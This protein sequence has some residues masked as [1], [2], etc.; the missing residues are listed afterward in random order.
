M[1][2]KNEIESRPKKTPLAIAKRQWS[3]EQTLANLSIEGM[4][5]SANADEARRAYIAGEITTEERVAIL[6]A[7]AQ[8][9][10]IG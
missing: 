8:E 3:S 4:R 7:L 10:M 1:K 6:M 2:K 9:K 5:P